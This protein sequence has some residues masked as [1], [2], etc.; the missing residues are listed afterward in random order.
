MVAYS[1]QSLEVLRTKID[2]VEVLASHIKLQ[3]S[4][5]YYK[6]CCPFHHEKTPSFTVQKGDFHYHCYGCGAHGDAIQFLTDHLKFS[7]QE[8]V[9]YLAEKFQVP[10]EKVTEEHRDYSLTELKQAMHQVKRFYQGYLLYTRE[11]RDALTYLFDRGFPL[12]FIHRFGIGLAPS[13]QAL[14]LEAMQKLKISIDT[15]EKLGLVKILDPQKTKM[16]FQERI[17]I[18]IEDISGHPIAFS[19]RKMK[20][21]AFGPKY[22]N[23]PETVLFKKSQS[24][25][26]LS[27]SRK[28][29]A[30]EQKALVVEGQFD[31]LRLIDSGF[32]FTV[33]GQGTAF[34]EYHAKEL[35]HL[36][37]KNIY[38]A[39]D[40][41]DAGQEAACKVGQIFQKQ[42]VE[43]WVLP[44]ENGKDP[45]LILREMG[46]AYFEKLLAQAQDYLSFVT[47]FF[48]LKG[49]PNTPAGKN[50]LM[51]KIVGMIKEWDHPLMVHEGYKRLSQLLQIPHG[52]IDPDGEVE[53][54]V[55]IRQIGSI[56]DHQ[57]DFVK[58]IEYDLLRWLIL[59][60]KEDQ[61]YYEWIFDHLKKEDF[62]LLHTQNLYELMKQIYF[63]GDTITPVKLAEKVE[64][65][66]MQLVIAEILQKKVN[67]ERKEEGIHET[68]QRILERN[69]LKEREKIKLKI[70]RGGLTEEEIMELAK[71]FDDLKTMPPQIRKKQEKGS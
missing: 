71:Q 16:Y 70:H 51:R 11:G 64:S 34:G 59:M 66:E 18:P 49:N 14:F 28:K 30:K 60:K 32:D 68:I 43:V 6:G 55:Q 12:Q 63:E 50:E 58:V 1:R 22:I 67:I 57:V 69:W 19:C 35:I 54:P 44:L 5:A 47:H 33:A 17:V 29:I 26:G 10:L 21:E 27:Y 9:E 24:L 15:L 37:V 56:H 23:S 38:L 2:L 36:G 52:L 3:K 13:S 42:G 61:E 8:A 62:L 31:A 40:G 25:F 20:E 45:D 46:P 7:F 41:D 65:I 4:G 53:V 39:F 48:S